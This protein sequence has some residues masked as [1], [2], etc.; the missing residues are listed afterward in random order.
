MR[1]VVVIPTYN[2]SENIKRL[3]PGLM[4]QFKN[5]PK[6]DIHILVID[7]NSPDGTGNAVLEL[8]KE[9][10]NTHLLIEK[11]KAGLGAAYVYGFK[12]AMKEQN[13][14][15]IVEMDADFQHDPK[16]F[17][18]MLTA[19]D[20]GSD[21]VIGSRYIKGGSVPKEWECY[22]KLLSVGGN[23]F[24]KF[25]LGIFDVN[26]FTTGFKIS[27][28]RGFVDKIDLDN[29]NSS[30]FAY[31]IDLLFR[32]HRLGAK[33]KEVPIRFGLRD[34]GDSKMEK[35]NMLD[36]LK[37]VM[38][39]RYQENKSFLKFVIVGFVGLFVDSGIFSILR[40]GYLGSTVASAVSGLIGMLT[41]FALNNI[42]SFGERKL[43][44]AKK[45]VAGFIIYCV[46]SY[47]P[48]IFRSWL[49]DFSII[50]FGDSALVAYTAFFTGILVGLIWNYTVYSRLIWKRSS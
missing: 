32:M 19:F 40:I 41:T 4:E 43:L 21:Y 23:M 27:R 37:V 47:I 26:D 46:S 3:I 25:V 16:D 2:E 45:K 9:Y 14:E 11:E 15:V 48:I 34:R 12:H 13:A 18:R 8:G 1:V 10:P 22:R 42:W 17:T 5:F 24:S 30:G 28:V 39:L 38:L 31:K 44:G 29:I 35:D 33:I 36:S 49:I 6:H 50:K 20:E 7:G